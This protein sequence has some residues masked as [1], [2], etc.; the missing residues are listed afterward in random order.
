MIC[1]VPNA[2][3]RQ[4]NVYKFCLVKTVMT[5]L[6]ECPTRRPRLLFPLPGTGPGSPPHLLIGLLSCLLLPWQSLFMDGPLSHFQSVN[7][8]PQPQNS[9][10]PLKYPPLHK[11]ISWLLQSLGAKSIIYPGWTIAMGITP[12][13]ISLIG[14]FTEGLLFF[15]GPKVGKD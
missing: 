8:R 12:K 13:F 15:E 7:A 9:P 5:T 11:A 1:A 2:L 10:L 4:G 6:P 14:G 3:S